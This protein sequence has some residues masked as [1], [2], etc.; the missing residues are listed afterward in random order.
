MT[1]LS[2]ASPLP[3]AAS[4]LS[5]VPAGAGAGKT[6]HIQTTL[7]RWVREGLVRP[8]RILAVTFTE[9][10]ADEL[11]QRIR[12]ALL[13]DGNLAAALAVERAYVSTIHGLGLRLLREHAFAAGASPEARLIAEAEQDLLIR[14]AIAEDPELAALADDLAAHGY[15]ARGPDAPAAE[16]QLRAG[17]LGVIGLLRTLGAR[18][19]APELADQV[20]AGIRAGYGPTGDAAT[21]DAAL[22]AA[23]RALLEAFPAAL[24]AHATSASS[25]ADFRDNHRAL[26]R[27]QAMIAE[28]RHDWA[29][30]QK[31]RKLRRTVRG[32]ATP[33]GY[34]ALAEAV[35]AAADGLLRHPGP[36]EQAVAHARAL[37][38]GAQRAMTDYAARK[39]AL[40]VI[41]F[42][43]MVAGAAELLQRQPAMLDAVLGEIDCVIVDEF[44]DTNP[45]QFAFLWTLAGQAPRALVVGDVKQAIMGFQ[46][47]DPR[48]TEA[49][50]ARFET[51]P[52][53]GNH[54]SDPRIMA[55]VN[56]LGPCLFGEGY[57]PLTPQRTAGEG[58]ALD[59]VVLPETRSTRKAAR[60]PLVMAD[61]VLAML[62]D[63][64][65]PVRDRHDGTTRAL[66]PRDIAVL[67]P[68][69]TLCQAYAA[70]LR[71]LGLPVRVAET[72]WWTSPAV[73][74]AAFAL[75]YA[76]DPADDH[77]ALWLATQGPDGLPLEPLLAGLARGER[78]ASPLLARLANLWPAALAMPADRLAAQVIAAAGLRPWCDAQPDPAQARADLLRFEAEAATFA[79]THRPVREAA[80]FHGDNG[81]VFLGWLEHRVTLKD[82][83]RRPNPAGA[84]A[85]GIEVLTWHAAKGRE[86]P[87]VVV[88]GLDTDHGPRA[89]TFSTGFADFDDLRDVL[90]TATLAQ[91]PGFAA[92]EK[93]AAFLAPLRPDADAT[94]RRLL[95]V[96]LTRARERLVLEWPKAPRGSGEESARI[97]TRALL[98]QGCGLA[99]ETGALKV[100]G[101]RFPA[102]IHHPDSDLPPAFAALA[103]GAPLPVP[104]RDGA[105]RLPPL[106][107]AI[108]TRPTPAL[109]MVLP[110]SSATATPHPLPP[111]RPVPLTEPLLTTRETDER[112]RLGAAADRGT[113]IHAAFCVLL[114]RPDLAPRV[115]AH[116]GLAD[117][118]VE[119]LARQARDLAAW[120]AGQGYDRLHVEQPLTIT[121]PDGSTQPAIA[122]LIAQGPAGLLLI[123]H[124]SGRIDDMEAGFA[125]YWPQLAAYADV[126]AAHT[127]TPLRG[128][129][130]FWTATGTLTLGDLGSGQSC[131]S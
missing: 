127:D 101:A 58:T 37:V 128:V 112:P 56:A 29:T 129:A 61:R 94:A 62:I 13:A 36:L 84:E 104:G 52:L 96:A 98:E 6:H 102:R 33:E 73:E 97:T 120:L 19:L 71:E 90:R 32:C 31:L 93:T 44:Q 113:A 86:W 125:G 21:L 30:W 65:V 126:I 81:H 17:L 60:P 77:A 70:A 5:I 18:G 103:D 49:L 59:L 15:S 115:A 50:V 12:G 4:S 79:A 119:V 25:E 114:Q 39:A 67:A 91:A 23:V 66:E 100:G 28:G 8:E 88:V 122:D 131:L 46:G 57:G 80:G 64:G 105:E 54:R 108:T 117:A 38:T 9:A 110:P 78:P 92:P 20:E 7:T 118:V 89:G 124:K 87:V 95:Y 75:R 47:A 85:E 107:H 10:A 63:D 27:A 16:D 99:V 1:V 35:I 69:H 111:L 3:A 11:R 2:A 76:C 130:V 68:K 24:T 42:A 74:A 106:H 34:D 72:G 116:T 48:L 43:D 22:G 14:Q 121:L 109:A 26:C 51:S 45:L 40:G 55:L 123:D 83:D 53:T 82:G 41:D